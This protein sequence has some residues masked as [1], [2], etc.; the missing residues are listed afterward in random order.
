VNL[1]VSEFDAAK[2]SGLALTCD[3]R[4]GLESLSE[5]LAGHRAP[6]E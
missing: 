3:A 4:L 2:H 5:A 6:E 1:N